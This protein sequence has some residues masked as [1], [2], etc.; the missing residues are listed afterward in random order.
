MSLAH[1]ANHLATQGRGEDTHLVHMTGKEL[2]AMQQLAESHGGSLTI[3]PKTGLP[4]AGFLSS[5]LPMVIGGAL[6]ATGIGAPLAALMVGAGDY[7]MTGSLTKGLMAGLSAWGGGELVGGLAEAGAATAADAIPAA[8]DAAEPIAL[9]TTQEGLAA[10]N[11]AEDTAGYAGDNAQGVANQVP[12]TSP[13]SGT[14]S[15]AG[16]PA[17]SFGQNMS[18]M[19]KGLGSIGSVISKN[20]GAAMAVAAP[21]LSGSLT[22]QPYVAPVAGSNTNPFG[23]KSISSN[24]QGQFP[25]QPNPAYRAQYPNYQQAPYTATAADGGLMGDKFDFASGGAYPMSQQDTSRYA[26][27]TQMPVGAQQVAASYEPQTNPL[28]GE[29]TANMAKGGI[30]AFSDGGPNYGNMMQDSEEVQRGLAMAT[31]RPVVETPAPDVGINY[32]EPEM[33][34]L[35]PVSRARKILENLSATSKVKLS[36]GLPQ[37][38]VLGSISGDPAMVEQQQ[39]E[40]QSKQAIVKEAQGGL[41]GY[42]AGG[43]SHLGDYSDGGHLLKGPGDGVSDSIPATIAG[44]QPARLATGEFVVP[45]RIVSELGNGSTDAGAKR[46]YAMMDRIKAKRAKTK[47]IAADTKAYKFLPA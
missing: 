6:A 7:A 25:A 42:A 39:A 4:E 47:D 3:N 26:T 29:M 41:M 27:P 12:N 15:Q 24:F 19:Y 2:A 17:P 9:D 35:D 22:K 11:A 36:N 20:P 34:R 43:Q 46:L 31:R 33:A 21:L 10:T 44:K 28:T 32:D 23:L 13:Y 18:N 8:A 40:E 16:P 14:P 45:A 37:A 5:V 30:A 1:I 38:G